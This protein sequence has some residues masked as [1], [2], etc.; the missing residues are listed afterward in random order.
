MP[1]FRYRAVDES[2]KI[3]KGFTESTEATTIESSIR[4]SGLYPISIRRVNPWIGRTIRFLLY[5]KVKRKDII[6]FAN[7]LSVMLRAGIPLLTALEDIASTT[8]NRYFREKI[9]SISRMVQMGSTLSDAIELQRDIFPDIF[10]RLIRVGEET[11]RLDQSLKDIAEHLQRIESLASAVKRALIYPIFTIVAT[12]SAMLF[13]LIYVLPKLAN[14]FREMNIPLPFL[15]RVIMA[16]SYFTKE[17]WYIILFAPVVIYILIKLLRKNRRIRYRLDKVKLSIPI[18][19][20][21]VHNKILAIFSEQMRILLVAGI[22]IDRVFEIVADVLGNDYAREAVLQVREDVLAGSTISDAL[23]KHKVFP[24]MLI[25]MV[26]VGEQTGALDEQFSF[27]SD[28]F[29]NMLEDISQKIGKML[30]PIIIVILGMFFIIIILG[31][32]IPVYDL[33]SKIGMGV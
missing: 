13:W 27:L 4:T 24:L 7:N 17:N 1:Y 6:E 12:L 19:R 33:V 8:E 28:Y 3:V 29:I 14:L 18:I 26:H 9:L 22:G 21:I 2:G 30:E 15:T 20:V 32:L 23:K 25:R 16:V 11:G 31:L 10:I 5:G